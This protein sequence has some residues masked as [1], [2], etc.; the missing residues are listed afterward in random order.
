MTITDDQG[1][2]YKL[3]EI[4]D[5]GCQSYMYCLEPIDEMEEE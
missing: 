4:F 3:V 5:H 1:N 2:R